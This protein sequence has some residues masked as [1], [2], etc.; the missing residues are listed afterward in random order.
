MFSSSREEHV[1][2]PLPAL[3]ID[4]TKVLAKALVGVESVSDTHIN[5]VALVA[6]NRLQIL[7]EETLWVIAIEVLIQVRPAPPPE[8]DLLQDCLLL[9]HAECPDTETVLEASHCNV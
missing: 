5:H 4:G 9:I 8:F 1:Q 7:D 3:E 2:A 6:L